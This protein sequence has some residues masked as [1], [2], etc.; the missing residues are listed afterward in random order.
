MPQKED[1]STDWSKV[2]MGFAVALVF[3]MQQY[4]A[5]QVSDLKEQVVPRHEFEAK[6]EKVMDKDEIM[7]ALQRLAERLDAIEGRTN[8]DK[9]R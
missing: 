1:G 2:F 3:V 7:F 9:T 8:D 5:M 6:A 4:H